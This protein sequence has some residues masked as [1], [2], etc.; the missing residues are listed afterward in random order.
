MEDDWSQIFFIDKVSGR[1]YRIYKFRGKSC[2]RTIL[3][4]KICNQ[5]AGYA[6]IQKDL[7]SAI[8]W[9]K[10]VGKIQ[11]GLPELD[12]EYHYGRNRESYD[13]IKGLFVAS[14]TFYGKC[15]SRCDGRPV[16]V[17]RIHL[18]EKF[19]ELHDLGISYRHNFAAHSGAE[20]VEM[21]RVVL[22]TPEKLKKGREVQFKIFAEIEQPDLIWH[23]EDVEIGWVELFEHVREYVIKKGQALHDKVV[24]EEV[25]PQG[26]DSFFK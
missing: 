21:A 14:L 5:I 10:E 18:D 12:G 4:S 3:N 19:H 13:I 24:K 22:V 8:V 16:K 9:M 23:K 26:V 11:A 20:K 17:E 2:K 15:F 6:L 1:K 25:I 7:K